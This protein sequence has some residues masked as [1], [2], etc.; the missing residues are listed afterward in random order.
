MMRDVKA[1]LREY[2]DVMDVPDDEDGLIRFVTEKFG[3]QR[4]Y[5]ASLDARYDGHKYGSCIGAGS[6]SSDGGCTFPEERQYC[7]D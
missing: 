6:H 5:Y 4:D 3:E 2:F 1:M 7:P